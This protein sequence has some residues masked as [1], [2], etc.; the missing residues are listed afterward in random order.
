MIPRKQSEIKADMQKA[1]E[2]VWKF[3]RELKEAKEYRKKH[4][5]HPADK[6]F[7]RTQSWMEEGRMRAPAEWQEKVCKVCGKIIATSHTE[8]IT[9]F[10]EVD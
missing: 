4:C 7:I 8:S 1:R 9:T 10:H 6:I 3:E 2:V 5:K